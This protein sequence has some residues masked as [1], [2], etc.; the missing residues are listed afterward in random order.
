MRLGTGWSDPTLFVAV[1]EFLRLGIPECTAGNE[2]DPDQNHHCYDQ[3]H[4][5]LPPFPPEV[6]QQSSLARIAVVAQLG[7][8]IAPNCAIRVGQSVHRAYPHC[9]VDKLVSTNGW[10][11]TAS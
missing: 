5:A 2:I 6:P 1:E 8:L 9:W 7:L 3:D 11:L 4:V 10:R